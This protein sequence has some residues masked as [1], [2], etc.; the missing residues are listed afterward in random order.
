M[1]FHVEKSLQRGLEFQKH[2]REFRHN[3]AEYPP[4][5]TLIGTGYKGWDYYPWDCERFTLLGLKGT[6][7]PTATTHPPGPNTVTDGTVSE[8]A[9]SMPPGIPHTK[10]VAEHNRPG[11]V[12]ENVK[13]G[14]GW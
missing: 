3:P 1:R 12:P 10:Y 7:E 5:A 14:Q 13:P 4:C 11:V 8:I 9:A 6:K 2:L